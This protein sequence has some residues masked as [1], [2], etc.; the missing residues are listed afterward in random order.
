MPSSVA[1]CPSGSC[2]NGAGE[3]A[4]PPH[5]K[6]AIETMPSQTAAKPQQEGMDADVALE[7]QAP[8]STIAHSL[9]GNGPLP[10][11]PTAPR[12]NTEHSPTGAA[13]ST[14]QAPLNT[15]T[16]LK[17]YSMRERAEMLNKVP[18]EIPGDGWCLMHAVSWYFERHEGHEP[19]WSVKKAAETYVQ[20][21]EWLIA[22]L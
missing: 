3:K 11:G 2:Q 14:A 12:D 20:A 16:R 6:P 10:T 9:H 22:H 13:A 8:Q 21:L 5:Q 4:M 17:S 19:V 15:D 7:P 18:M 1:C